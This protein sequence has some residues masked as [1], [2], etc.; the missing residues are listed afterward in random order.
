M[1][2]KTSSFSPFSPFS[3]PGSV[4]GIGIVTLLMNLSTIIIFSLSPKYLTAVL[5]VSTLSLGIFEG[6]VE[7]VAWFTRIFAGLISDYMRKRRPLLFVAYGLAAISRPIFALA[8]SF[9]W[10]FIARSV[11]RLGNGLQA[12]PREALVGDSAPKGAKGACYGLRQT[13]GVTGSLLG[14]LGLIFWT[15]EQGVDYQSIFWFAS[16]PPVLALIALA[17]MVKEPKVITREEGKESA[18]RRFSFNDLESLKIE[19]WLVVFVGSLFMLSNYSGAFMILQANNVTHSDA[20]APLVMIFQNL[21]SMLAAYPVGRLSDRIDRRKL[22]GIGFLLTIGSN[23]LLGTAQTQTFIIG[24]AALWGM[25]LGITQ[26]LLVA[27]IADA[28]SPWVRGTAFGIYYVVIALSLF[29]TNTLTGKIFGLTTPFQDLP[30]ILQGITPS[31]LLTFSGPQTVF[32]VSSV[33]ALI[34]FLCLPILKAPE[35]MN[36]LAK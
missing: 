30:A 7:A 22:L 24:G 6:V 21:A 28:T 35:K 33:F 15:S 9:L 29:L 4:W 10:I 25:Q 17:L 13:L 3:L 18:R 19:Y 12:T 31:F 27:K 26:S 20:T 11:D 2:D 34:A 23:Y 8:P 5:G 16:I 1:A 14:A 36:I 32:L